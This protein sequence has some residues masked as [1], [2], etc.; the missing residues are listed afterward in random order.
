MVRVDTAL[1][2][3]QNAQTEWSQ[4]SRVKREREP[5]PPRSP[6]IEEKHVPC[7]VSSLWRLETEAGN[8]GPCGNSPAP[9]HQATANE[10]AQH[11]GGP[12]GRRQTDKT[13]LPHTPYSSTRVYNPRT[14]NPI[15]APELSG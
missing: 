3:L 11:Q 6:H 4:E 13:V 2:E 12:H 10:A 9:R 14:Q 15:R 1:V 5:G 8:K 7:L